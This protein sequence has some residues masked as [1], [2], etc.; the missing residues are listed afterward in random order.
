MSNITPC[1]P[2]CGKVAKVRSVLKGF[3][4]G[5]CGHTFKTDGVWV[6]PSV[7]DALRVRGGG[8]GN[9]QTRPEIGNRKAS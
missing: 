1:C 6:L 8:W 9:K 3:Y 7:A 2:K 5:G 4:C